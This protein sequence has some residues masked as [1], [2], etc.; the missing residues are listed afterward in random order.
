VNDQL[1]DQITALMQKLDAVAGS[2]PA[3]PDN[4]VGVPPASMQNLNYFADTLTDLENAVESA[5]AAPTPDARTGFKLQSKALEPV[6]QKWRQLQLTDLP[7]M[8][9]A[10]QKAGQPALKF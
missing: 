10:L 6:M 3:D 8:N 2:P 7:Q 9:A 5:D 4:S 1:A